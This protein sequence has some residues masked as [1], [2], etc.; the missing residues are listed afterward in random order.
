MNQKVSAGVCMKWF[1]IFALIISISVTIY[2]P[3]SSAPRVN[4]QPRFMIGTQT[5]NGN[6]LSVMATAFRAQGNS[7]SS[8]FQIHA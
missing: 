6:L 3:L 4:M 8:T 2:P 7:L 5:G 1:V